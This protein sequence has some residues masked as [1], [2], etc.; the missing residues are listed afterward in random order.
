MYDIEERPMKRM[1]DQNEIAAGASRFARAL[2]MYDSQNK[3]VIFSGDLLFPSMLS[4]RFGGEQMIYP[5]EQFNVD[6]SCLG[7]HELDQGFDHAEKMLAQI[8][9][10][11]IL[12]NL[13]QKDK[14][15]RPLAG[16]EPWKVL[17][18]SGFK[19]G[20]M[21]FAEKEWLDQLNPDIDCNLL[22]YH[23]YNQKL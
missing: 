21:G 9:C 14:G 6:I 12:S 1:E 5:F 17:E 10:P 20:F 13:F 8:S 2:H 23:D 11:W 7:N 18:H 4:T 3:L 15:M 19:I 22:E 16:V